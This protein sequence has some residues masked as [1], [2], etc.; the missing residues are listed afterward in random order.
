MSC[1]EVAVLVVFKLLVVLRPVVMVESTEVEAVGEPA[2]RDL[3]EHTVPEAPV[4]NLEDPAA[5][6]DM[7][8]REP[9]LLDCLWN[10]LVQVLEARAT[11]MAEDLAVVEAMEVPV[12]LGHL[13]LRG[14]VE[15]LPEDLAEA[16]ATVAKAVTAPVEDLT[17]VSVVAV[18]AAATELPAYLDLHYAVEGAAAM[19]LPN[20][21]EVER[22]AQ[23]Q[24]PA[25]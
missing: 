16:A 19:A 6:A 4:V 8:L 21:V 22:T 18:G 1:T 24:I 15:D 13:Q 3:L 12:G 14:Q 7:A 5:L 10:L 20:T 25:L 9:I 23:V 17:T 11:P 2:E